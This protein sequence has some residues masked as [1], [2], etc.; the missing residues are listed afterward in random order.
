MSDI[1]I[2]LKDCVSRPDQSGIFPLRAIV[3]YLF[4]FLLCQVRWQVLQ[5]LAQPAVV[6]NR[7]AQSMQAG[8]CNGVRSKSA[9]PREQGADGHFPQYNI[10]RNPLSCF[11]CTLQWGVIL[12]AGGLCLRSAGRQ[13]GQV[14]Q[15]TAHTHYME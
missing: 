14:V 13:C 8:A 2:P 15:Q 7:A 5:P 3:D 4:G 1:K 10:D 12:F 6:Q 11:A 9:N